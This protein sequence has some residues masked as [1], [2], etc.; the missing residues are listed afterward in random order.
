MNLNGDIELKISEFI[1]SYNSLLDLEKNLKNNYN[2]DEF[3]LEEDYKKY[4]V[5]K[6]LVNKNNKSNNLNHIYNNFIKY[7]NDFISQLKDKYYQNI[8]IEQIY[9]QDAKEENIPKFSSSDNEFLKIVMNNTEIINVEAEADNSRQKIF[10]FNFKD[11]ENDLAEKNKPGLKMFNIGKIRTIKYSGDPDNESIIDDFIKKYKSKDINQKQKD[12]IIKKF[13]ENFGSD[14]INDFLSEI[15]KLMYFILKHDC[16]EEDEIHTIFNHND[17][18]IIK[19]ELIKSFFNP[20]TDM[21]DEDYLTSMDNDTQNDNA[22]D[23]INYNISNL[24]PIYQ[25]IENLSKNN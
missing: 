5:E 2:N 13:S 1:K 22:I 9:V 25:I 11:I 6:F 19:L 23:E 8:I 18:N 4:S 12:D 15:Q 24:Y 10:K 20:T 7:Q 17:F 14:K 21:D 3:K 16:K